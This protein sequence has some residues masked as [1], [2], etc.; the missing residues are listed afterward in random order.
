MKTGFLR[1]LDSALI[2][3]SDVAFLLQWLC[4]AK[5]RSVEVIDSLHVLTELAIGILSLPNGVFVLNVPASSSRAYWF[6]TSGVSKY[7]H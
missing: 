3:S 7:H 6:S 4:V 1:I 2:V 5:N